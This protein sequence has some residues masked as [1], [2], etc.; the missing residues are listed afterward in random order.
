MQRIQRDLWALVLVSTLAL[1][2]PAAARA[3]ATLPLAP[4]A[5]PTLSPVPASTPAK[6]PALTA[7]YI[8][9]GAALLTLLVVSAHN[10]CERDPALC[11]CGDTNND[12]F[13]TDNARH[14]FSVALRVPLP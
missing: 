4:A 8:V 2:F 7:L 6:R 11:S 3:D 9:A 5:I 13:N 1:Q 10:Q 14:G 12:Q